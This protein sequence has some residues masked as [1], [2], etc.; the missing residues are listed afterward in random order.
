[1]HSADD[2]ASRHQKMLHQRELAIKRQ[3]DMA[4]S[5]FGGVGV[6][7]QLN[8]PSDTSTVQGLQSKALGWGKMLQAGIDG[9]GACSSTMMRIIVPAVEEESRSPVTGTFMPSPRQ[10]LPTAQLNAAV[11]PKKPAFQE[12]ALESG[13]D[14]QG[15]APAKEK[16]WGHALWKPWGASKS[17]SKSTVS[18]I[19]ENRVCV[20]SAA[21]N[22]FHSESHRLVSIDRAATPWELPS[23]F[24]ACCAVSID[25]PERRAAASIDRAGTP[26]EPPCDAEAR[27]AVSI[28]SPARRAGSIDRAATP[29]EPVCAASARCTVSLDSLDSPARHAISVD[30]AAT[31]WEAPSASL[32]VLEESMGSALDRSIG[33]DVSSIPGFSQQWPASSGHASTRGRSK[34]CCFPQGPEQEQTSSKIRAQYSQ[35]DRIGVADNQTEPIEKGCDD[36]CDSGIEQIVSKYHR[37]PNQKKSRINRFMS[38]VSDLQLPIKRRV[39]K[40]EGSN[41]I[42]IEVNP[43]HST[44]TR[45]LVRPIMDLD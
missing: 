2:P 14:S 32:N 28:D 9:G 25:S 23:A 42:R 16:S 17:S 11:S 15:E 34:P 20:L 40:P 3:R 10:G 38:S 5:S 27:F 6:T 21:D 35:H 45:T 8:A 36:D 13:E 30:R 18:I 29:W 26:W 19:E 4:K 43:A 7:A 1:M 24:S 31:P 12:S 39:A 22:S 33:S 41:A 37:S 44:P